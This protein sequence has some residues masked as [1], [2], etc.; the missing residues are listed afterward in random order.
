MSLPDTT[1]LAN[2]PADGTHLNDTGAEIYADMIN[3]FLSKDIVNSIGTSKWD[4][5]KFY[6][7]ANPGSVNYPGNI[8]LSVIPKICILDNT[9]I[10]VSDI[11]NTGF[12]A[13]GNG[14]FTYMAVVNI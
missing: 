8:E 7:V 9:D 4:N 11:T 10:V 12:S 5:E 3:Q 13:T 14:L 6:A 2:A 1:I